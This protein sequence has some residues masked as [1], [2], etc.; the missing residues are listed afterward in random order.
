VTEILDV[1]LKKICL[2]RI[3]SSF[4]YTYLHPSSGANEVS[5]ESWQLIP[6]VHDEGDGLI[7]CK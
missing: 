5:R 1:D 4:Y 3:L 2:P 6:A 7:L